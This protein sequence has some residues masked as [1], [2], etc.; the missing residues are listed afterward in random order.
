[1]AK[2]VDAPLSGGGA[3][4]C[5]G[6]TPVLGTVLLRSEYGFA[7]RGVQVPT[8]AD[9]SQAMSRILVKLRYPVTCFSGFDSCSEYYVTQN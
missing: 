7:S 1:M 8:I 2:L 3:A 5:A 6:S 4:R 9:G